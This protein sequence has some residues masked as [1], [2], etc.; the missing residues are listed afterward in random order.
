M[1]K[2]LLNY[3]PKEYVLNVIIIAIYLIAAIPLFKNAYLAWNK[4]QFLN[5]FWSI[6]DPGFKTSIRLPIGIILILETCFL[7]IGFI[8]I[9]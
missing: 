8:T 1:I 2:D 4:N 3:Y 9:N 7:M 5:W 6:K